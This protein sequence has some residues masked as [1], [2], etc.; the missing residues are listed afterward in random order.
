MTLA[1]R[2]ASYS[3]LGRP[4]EVKVQTEK[5]G[6]IAP[7]LTLGLVPNVASYKISEVLEKFVFWLRNA[8]QVRSQR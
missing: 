3:A 5:I 8:G 7:A 4:E 6:Q 2:A 1:L